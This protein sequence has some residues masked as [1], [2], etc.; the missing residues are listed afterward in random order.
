MSSSLLEQGV[1]ALE[2]HSSQS[3]YAASC[4]LAKPSIRS[5]SSINT[6]CELVGSAPDR[7][8]LQLLLTLTQHAAPAGG[9]STKLSV[10]SA[11]NDSRLRRSFC[12]NSRLCA[13]NGCGLVA[14]TSI[15]STMYGS[16][17]AAGRQSVIAPHCWIRVHAGRLIA[18]ALQPTPTLNSMSAGSLNRPLVTASIC[19]TCAA[20]NRSTFCWIAPRPGPG[21]RIL[22]VEKSKKQRCLSLNATCTSSWSAIRCISH[23]LSHSWSPASIPHKGPSL[24][25]HSLLQ[26]CCDDSAI[27]S[28][29]PRHA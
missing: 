11:S 2:Q 28:P 15:P 1:C 21:I 23:R 3:S 4:N 14:A 8:S 10:S 13:Q 17:S 5:S 27:A 26:P 20:C 18:A 6:S 24:Y 25:D 29:A 16:T 22:A 19:C 12:V 7:A 9:A